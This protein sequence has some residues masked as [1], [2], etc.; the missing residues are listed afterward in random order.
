MGERFGW[1]SEAVAGYA[2]TGVSLIGLSRTGLVPAGRSD[3]G[4]IY[5]F[6]PRLQRTLH[7]PLE[8]PI[9]WFLTGTLFV[10][11]LG[12]AAGQL[13]YCRTGRGRVAGLLG[14]AIVAALCYRIGD[15]Y[16]FPASLAL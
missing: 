9:R 1:L 13:L 10:A 12:G 16:V 15:V 5:F 8:Q 3:D 6:V 4:G 11:I 2:K 14:L 7:L